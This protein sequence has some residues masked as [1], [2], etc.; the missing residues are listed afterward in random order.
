MDKEKTRE[1]FEDWWDARGRGLFRKLG[2]E[3]DSYAKIRTWEA[4][5]DGYGQGMGD[6]NEA[7]HEFL[8]E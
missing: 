6:L 1:R 4:Y 3:A 8:D 7:M 5:W 2:K